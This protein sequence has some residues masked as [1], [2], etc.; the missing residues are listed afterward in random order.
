MAFLVL[1]QL[2]LIWLMITARATFTQL[3]LMN[4]AELLLTLLIA[5]AF[6]SRTLRAL[7][8]RL[9]EILWLAIFSAFILL[10]CNAVE[11]DSEAQLGALVS[12]DNV[13]HGLIYLAITIGMWLL[14]AMSSGNPRH[15]W[16][17]NV[18][19]PT[20]AGF[21]A[22]CVVLVVAM[23]MGCLVSWLLDQSQPKAHTVAIVHVVEAGVL[24]AAFS[25]VRVGFQ[26]MMMTML[27]D[28]AIRKAEQKYFFDSNGPAAS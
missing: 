17:V 12:S 4:S 16:I 27:S 5:N 8:W 13:H 14:L 26:W 28:D 10:V 25:I 11:S 20:S 23:L 3:M 24:M 7:G 18:T 19:M 6:F 9:A 2:Y 1:G 21:V 15:W 22:M